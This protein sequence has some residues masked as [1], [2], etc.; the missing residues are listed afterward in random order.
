MCGM[1]NWNVF[2]VWM[3]FDL[4][5]KI[6]LERFFVSCTNRR[7][8]F[9]SPHQFVPSFFLKKNG[10]T[11]ASFRL[12][13]VF[14]SKHYKFLQQIDVKKCPFSIRGRDSN[15]QPLERESLPI[16]TTPGLP[17]FFFFF[18][19]FFIETVAREQVCCNKKRRRRQKVLFNFSSKLQKTLL[20]I[21]KNDTVEMIYVAVK[22]WSRVREPV[23]P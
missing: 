22:R 13:L 8:L 17:P 6:L 9:P 7:S 3:L 19:T 20:Q 4:H 11:P 16:S 5:F 12:F 14:S 21:F 2:D 10:P 18:I 23:W 15:P 1:A